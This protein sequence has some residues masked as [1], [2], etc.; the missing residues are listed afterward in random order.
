MLYQIMTDINNNLSAISDQMNH[1]TNA[2][3]KIEINT[4]P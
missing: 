3:N 2:L 1:V 4:L